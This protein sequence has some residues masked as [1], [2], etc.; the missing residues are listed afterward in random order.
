MQTEKLLNYLNQNI[1]EEDRKTYNK[2]LNHIKKRHMKS[3]SAL[4]STYNIDK[5]KINFASG[6]QLTDDYI[7]KLESLISY[8]KRIIDN[9]I[10]ISNYDASLF[11]FENLLDLSSANKIDN[12][13]QYLYTFDTYYDKISI[14]K[15]LV[16]NPLLILTITTRKRL[17]LGLIEK[18]AYDFCNNHA[19][20]EDRIEE[21]D[22]DL[23]AINN[24][25][26]NYILENNYDAIVQPEIIKEAIMDYFK[27]NDELYYY[28]AD[29]EERI[30]KSVN[31]LIESK[32]QQ[33]GASSSFRFKLFDSFLP[34]VNVMLL[35]IMF[36]ITIATG[37]KLTLLAVP[38]FMYS[39]FT[40]SL[41]FIRI[42][43]INDKKDSF[44]FKYY[45]KYAS[46]LTRFKVLSVTGV[47]MSLV[48]LIFFTNVYGMISAVNDW[49][50]KLY[51]GQAIV[52]TLTI[53]LIVI[54]AIILFLSSKL[55]KNQF[56]NI[57]FFMAIFYLIIVL[58]IRSN[59]FNFTAFE[60]SSIYFSVFAI[61]IVLFTLLSSD[62]K[63]RT[64][65]FLAV[66]CL[67]IIIMLALNNEFYLR[68]ITQNISFFN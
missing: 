37:F 27:T 36:I 39:I 19:I 50:N 31:A 65:I 66:L 28:C 45:A 42:N 20:V 23:S 67:D 26:K 10:N 40:I 59:L 58:S 7:N 9:K 6:E 12:L 52:T 49:I 55:L 54:G 25:K 32:S 5:K 14:S 62:Y 33:E 24:F 53:L 44:S 34:L 57:S 11:T 61:A 3:L 29:T 35:V 48:Y 56:F 17:D 8:C 38:L 30:S 41:Y 4:V 13:L 46:R 15:D 47:V 18:H 22:S 2:L 64:S 51:N 60:G 43:T 21:V 16:K 1:N 68:V 63:I